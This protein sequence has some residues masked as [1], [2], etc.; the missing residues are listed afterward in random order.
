MVIG[1]KKRILVLDQIE[2]ETFSR[3][4]LN[5]PQGIG[6]S[7]DE[8]LN[9]TM[10]RGWSSG[11][12]QK[13]FSARSKRAQDPLIDLSSSTVNDRAAKG[14]S[15]VKLE[16]AENNQNSNVPHEHFKV[17]PK[18]EIVL[19][20]VWRNEDRY[21]FENYRLCGTRFPFNYKGIEKKRM[22]SRWLWR[23]GDL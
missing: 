23:P 2:V 16:R 19:K 7:K 21:R 1:V 11:L 6:E 18:N 5:D 20:R 17:D 15:K 4:D 22:L 13:H 9:H 8:T 12:G 10:W 14:I 3:I